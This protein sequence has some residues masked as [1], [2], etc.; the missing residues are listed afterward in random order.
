M[1]DYSDDDVRAVARALFDN[2]VYWDN[3]STGCRNPGDGYACMYCGVDEFGS[4]EAL[5]HSIECP[6]LIAQD[7]LT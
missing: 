1:T 3:G 2:A 4:R 6:A 7:L 5:K